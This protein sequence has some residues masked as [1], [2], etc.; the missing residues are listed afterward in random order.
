MV[1][2]QVGNGSKRT[3]QPLRPSVRRGPK[4][5]ITEEMAIANIQTVYRRI[6]Q[7]GMLTRKL[8]MAHG[9]FGIR[10]I[11]RK[12]GWKRICEM[13]RIPC[14]VRG[15]KKLHWHQCPH[16]EK[17]KA[18]SRFRYCWDCRRR[19]KRNSGGVA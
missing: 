1:G 19:H 18:S 7:P 16:C 11:E 4:F 15:S 3:N 2:A 10:S 12:W 17:G 13:A 5:E 6:G 9:S 8:Y 14:G